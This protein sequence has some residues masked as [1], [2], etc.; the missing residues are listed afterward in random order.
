MSRTRTIDPTFVQSHPTGLVSREACLGIA[1]DRGRATPDRAQ[2]L[3]ALHSCE[4]DAATLLP[5]WRVELE[6][7]DRI[8][9][10]WSGTLLPSSSEQTLESRI[11]ELRA[12]F[13]EIGRKRLNQKDC[14]G[15]NGIRE[16]FE[17]MPFRENAELAGGLTSSR[18]R[19]VNLRPPQGYPRRF[20]RS[21]TSRG[22]REGL[23][24]NTI[25]TRAA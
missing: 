9:P 15:P 19:F 1:D 2:L 22:T 3:A 11:R 14:D 6:R 20:E 18:R 17:E 21:R 12:N 25:K 7:G 23:A 24:R 10:P 4:S 5:A 16:S 8:A 13:R